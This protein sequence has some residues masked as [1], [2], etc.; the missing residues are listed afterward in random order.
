LKNSGILL[1]N[2]VCLLIGGVTLNGLIKKNNRACRYKFMKNVIRYER[3]VKVST[4]YEWVR[5][6][7]HKIS[8]ITFD[9]WKDAMLLIANDN[10]G[11]E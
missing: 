9:I 5:I 1:K 4:G 3:R 2:V 8:E 10:K 6:K 11:E 7:S